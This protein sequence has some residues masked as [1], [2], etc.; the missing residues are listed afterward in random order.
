RCGKTSIQEVLF[1]GLPPKDAF[2][3]EPTTKVVKTA[4]ESDQSSTV[5]PLEIWDCPGS[6]TIQTLPM[7]LSQF[8][9]IAFV[10]DIQDHHQQPIARL[11]ELVITAYQENQNVN[12]EVFVHK[13]EALSEEYKI[14]NFK[15]IQ[16]RV[17]EELDDYD[18]GHI[19]MNFYLTSIHDH[20]LQDAFSKVV[21]KLIDSLPYIEDLLNVFCGNSQ[22]TKAFLFDV[23]SRLY[24]ATDASPVDSATHS[25]CSDFLLTLNSFGPLYK[26]AS[27]FEERRKLF[28]SQLVQ[29]PSASIQGSPSASPR[30]PSSFDKG[31]LPDTDQVTDPPKALFYPSASTSL[32]P[33]STETTVTC[34]LITPQLALLALIPTQ[35]FEGRR[36]LVEYN[37]VYFREGVQEIWQV[38]REARTRG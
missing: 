7:P 3:I 4:Y 37:V 16:Q 26:W 29:P 27:T 35:T 33:G 13:A 14:E 15:H 11:V 19:P 8:P 23:K 31:K 6:L 28:P 2:F 21:H 1:K 17:L 38:E 30:S 10:I 9:T 12:L 24:V 25:L 36:G 20:S 34:Y 5:I 18:Y 22:A 32:S